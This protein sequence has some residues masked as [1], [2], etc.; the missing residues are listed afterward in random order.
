MSRPDPFAWIPRPTP[1]VDGN[2]HG[3]SRPLAFAPPS[4]ET[5]IMESDA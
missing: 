5:G 4:S 2:A 1:F 3:E